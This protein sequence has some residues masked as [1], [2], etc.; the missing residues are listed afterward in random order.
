[1]RQKFF[2]F[3]SLKSGVCTKIPVTLLRP[4]QRSQD[5]EALLITNRE[6]PDLRLHVE[7][8]PVLLAELVGA[9][10]QRRAASGRGPGSR[11]SP[12]NRFSAAVRA[13]TSREC[14]CTIP[15]PSV[16]ACLGD[17]SVT[18]SPPI[19]ISPSSGAR[20]PERTFI[21]VVLPAPFFSEQGVDLALAQ[22]EVHGVVGCQ[23][24]VS[25]GDPAEGD[26]RLIAHARRP[27]ACYRV[28]GC[29]AGLDP[30]D[31]PLPLAVEELVAELLAGLDLDLA[32]VVGD[33]ADEWNFRAGDQVVERLLDLRLDVRGSVGPQS[34]N[35]NEVAG[36]RN[37][38]C[39]E[40]NSPFWIASN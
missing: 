2:A 22:V 15:I 3:N 37:S 33:R 28:L 25:L 36:S 11:S 30:L 18:G 7:L 16:R 40:T 21:S 23:I 26:E 10:D 5:L 13:S 20:T 31:V 14:W 39:S 32:L 38:S 17:R 12:M 35:L 19:R 8:E 34:S 29:S 1:M 24:A 9:S 6:L 4:G 27:A